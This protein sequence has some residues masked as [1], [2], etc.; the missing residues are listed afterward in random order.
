MKSTV[1]IRVL[2]TAIGGSGHGEQVLKALKLSQLLNLR[3]FGTDSSTICP[4]QKQVEKFFVLPSADSPLYKTELFEILKENDIDVL[5]H[6]SEAELKVFLEIREELEALGVLLLINSS[7]VIKTCMNKEKTF[8]VL[9]KLGFST[10]H[11]QSIRTFAEIDEI[12]WFP[13]V[14][15]PN[16]GSGGSANVYICQ[17]TKEL[18]NLSHYLHLEDSEISFMIQ[19]YVGTPENEYTFGVLSTLDGKLIDSIGVHRLLRSQLN[20]KTKVKNRTNRSEL[21]PNLVISSGVSHGSVGRFSEVSY[22]CEEIAAALESCGPLNIQF[23]LVGGKVQVFEINPRFSGT[24]SIRAMA[25]FNEPEILIR[26]H[27]LRETFDQRIGYSNM[28]IIRGLVEY[29]L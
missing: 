2:I 24:T 4:Q 13:V 20:I 7:D 27:L 15:K 29:V 22:Q 1:E 3:L 17:S 23:R 11:F 14:V 12:D 6:G 16:L 26:H 19:E 8:L 25:G 28:T 18:Q 9:N 5:I 21:G 10:P